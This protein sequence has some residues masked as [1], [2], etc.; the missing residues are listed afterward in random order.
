MA[1][2]ETGFV[3]KGVKFA[4]DKLGAGLNHFRGSG[5]ST[6]TSA[7]P[8]GFRSMAT[9][10]MNSLDNSIGKVANWRPLPGLQ[11]KIFGETPKVPRPFG[12]EG[13]YNSIG[14][15]ARG[16]AGNLGI[17]YVVGKT[18]GG[19]VDAIQTPTE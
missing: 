11:D 18:M 6:P 3:K 16:V 1:V 4:A 7:A 17:G 14:Q 19:A 13:P 12:I 15:A 5:A 2:E 8:S 9:G 10:A